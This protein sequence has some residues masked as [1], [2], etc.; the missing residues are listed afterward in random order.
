MNIDKLVFRIAG[1]FILLSLVLSQLHS[2]YWLWF[3]AFVG[4]EYAAGLVY[5]VLPAGESSGA[6]ESAGRAGVL[7]AVY[8]ARPR[9]P[10]ARCLAFCG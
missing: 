9:T 8:S 5:R 1:L 7:A 4:G 2:M 3:A 10:P 6:V